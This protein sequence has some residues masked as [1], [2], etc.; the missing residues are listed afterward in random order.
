[1]IL[2]TVFLGRASTHRMVLRSHR[3]G[4]VRVAS[5][6][7]RVTQKSVWG[8]ELFYGNIAERHNN[9]SHA[10][11]SRSHPLAAQGKLL[12][13]EPMLLPEK[14]SP[15]LA[16]DTIFRFNVGGMFSRG[17]SFP[18]HVYVDCVRKKLGTWTEK[19]DA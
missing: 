19:K 6:V 8:L 7:N 13:V 4:R 14:K 5:K 9:F 1:M 17:R 12:P 18:S 10:D 16:M 3:L 2:R 11:Q 15:L